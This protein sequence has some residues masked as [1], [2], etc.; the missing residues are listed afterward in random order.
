MVV[1]LLG[2]TLWNPFFEIHL[3][4]I[5][6]RRNSLN[7]ETVFFRFLFYYY[8]HPTDI[9][10]T[11]DKPIII[12]IDHHVYYLGRGVVVLGSRDYFHANILCGLAMPMRALIRH[13]HRGSIKTILATMMKMDWNDNRL[14][15][16]IWY[17]VFA[18][19]ILCAPVYEIF[20]KD[21]EILALQL[22]KHP[23][24]KLL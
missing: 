2:R 7:F 9:T 5:L 24:N 23:Y 16:R 1:F 20:R 6:K 15:T 3:E 19:P 17:G 4:G 18:A 13:W 14:H 11:P 10:K 21:L 12:K 8:G 22:T